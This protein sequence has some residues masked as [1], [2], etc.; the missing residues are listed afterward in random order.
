MWSLHIIELY[1]FF[2]CLPW[3][4]CYYLQHRLHIFPEWGD[5]GVGILQVLVFNTGCGADTEQPCCI[6]IFFRRQFHDLGQLNVHTRYW[7]VRRP[8]NLEKNVTVSQ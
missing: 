3:L 1:I 7:L 5:I 4:F 6:Q 2:Q 8:D